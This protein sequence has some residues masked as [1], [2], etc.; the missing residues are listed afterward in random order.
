MTTVEEKNSLAIIAH[1]LKEPL[2]T[3]RQLSLSLPAASPEEIAATIQPQLLKT[4]EQA[5]KQVDDLL[6]ITRAEKGLYPTEPISVPAVCL[7]V[8]NEL[9]YLYRENHKSL[10]S[11]F[12]NH[13]PLVLANRE[14]L[15]SIIYNFTTNALHY[16][17]H[18][19]TATLSVRRRANYLR[20][21]VRDQGPALPTKIWRQ[22][23]QGWLDNP[24][25]IA[26]RPGSSGLGLYISTKFARAM[27]AKIGAIRHRDGTTFYLDLPTAVQ[28]SLFMK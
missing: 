10:H 18:S 25:A 12:Q 26:M 17:D 21:S 8:A 13:S 4:S 9:R 15:H 6:K 27:N 28:Q 16:S 24:T 7:D 11:V 1:D 5:L 20:I 23:Q 2:I 3:L 19:T 14:L 22:L